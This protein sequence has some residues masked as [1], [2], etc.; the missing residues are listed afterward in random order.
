MM[1][2]ALINS[3]NEPVKE[4]QILYLYLNILGLSYQANRPDYTSTTTV[5]IYNR[6]LGLIGIDTT[7]NTLDP[8]FQNPSTVIQIILPASYISPRDIP[9]SQFSTDNSPDGGTS[10][11]T[12]YSSDWAGLNPFLSLI[13]PAETALELGIDYVLVPSGGFILLNSGN[14]PT[15]VDGQTIRSVAYAVA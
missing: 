2:L 12:Y 3:G 11:N 7:V 10:R 15:I 9:W 1:Y 5:T 4:A 13:S 8:N 14:L 6:L